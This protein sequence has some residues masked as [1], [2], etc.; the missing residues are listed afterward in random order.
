VCIEQKKRRGLLSAKLLPATF[1]S[2]RTTASHFTPSAMSLGD[3][4]DHTDIERMEHDLRSQFEKS[5]GPAA[6]RAQDISLAVNVAKARE[7][8]RWEFGYLCT[9][10]IGTG[11]R[12]MQTLKFP[13][14]MLLPISAMAFVTA[15]EYDL[16]YGS[17]LRRINMEAMRILQRESYKY[18]RQS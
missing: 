3:S 13:V 6:L 17:K 2:I 5:M 4:S 15:Y 1:Y 12:W 18:F 16:G 7:R 11:V 9:L 14:P 10:T 8:F